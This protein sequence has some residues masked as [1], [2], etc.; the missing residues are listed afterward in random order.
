[1]SEIMVEK[2]LECPVNAAIAI[3]AGKWKPTIL[4]ELREGARRFSD[5]KRDVPGISEKVLTAHLRELEADGIVSR[6]EFREGGILATEYAYTD[7]GL[8]LKP[9]LDALADWG[10]RHKRLGA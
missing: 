5:L 1:M 2:I 8:T 7:Y 3:I 6:R 9:I 4:C 10:A